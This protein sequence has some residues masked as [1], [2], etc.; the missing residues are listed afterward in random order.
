[1]CGAASGQHRS[2][3]PRAEAGT[4]GGGFLLFEQTD[5]GEE[6][7]GRE[8]EIPSP[9]SIS[10]GTG[11]RGEWLLLSLNFYYGSGGAPWGCPRS[12]AWGFL[13]GQEGAA[14]PAFGSP[15]QLVVILC[16]S[17]QGSC[18]L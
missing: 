12:K 7:T 1:M 15:E 9:C 17:F 13:S 14:G 16:G 4:A 10:V 6:R 18:W 3:S 11:K 5:L 8:A 2:G